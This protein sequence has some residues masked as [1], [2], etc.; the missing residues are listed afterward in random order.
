[1]GIDEPQPSPSRRSVRRLGWLAA[2][3]LV[4]WTHPKPAAPSAARAVYRWSPN[5]AAGAPEP[6]HQKAETSVAIDGR[7]TIWLS[8]L[9]ATY[10]RVAT[11]TWIDWPRRVL[12]TSSADQGRGFGPPAEVT[13]SGTDEMLGLDPQGRLWLTWVDFARRELLVER[14]G[15]PPVACPSVGAGKHYDQ[16]SLVF[17]PDGSVEV[18]GVVLPEPQEVAQC[19]RRRAEHK[20]VEPDCGAPVVLVGRVDPAG[21]CS[22]STQVAS[23]GE[24]PQLA[25]TAGGALVVGPRGFARSAGHSSG[26]GPVQRRAFGD[27]LARVATSPDRSAVYVVGDAAAGG[28]IL[29]TTRDLG[30]T[31]ATT[32]IDGGARAHA[33]RFPA[34]AVARTGRIHV[35]WMDDHEGFGAVYHAWSDDQGRS[36]SPPTRVSDRPFPFPASAPPPPPATQD[37]SWVGDYLSIA[38]SGELAVIAWADQRSGSTQSAV[39]V[40]VGRP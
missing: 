38:A 2:G 1:M 33:W 6:G 21:R 22:G 23:L 39:Y 4:A 34:I 18:A 40:A 19:A 26:F 13:A 9:D 35:A 32:R 27:A 5:V 12:L 30:Q 10:H 15:A 17:A 3:A 7:G 36:F 14:V 29:H 20:Q 31:W 11:G 28:L 16:A 37:G 8:F 24:L 25:L